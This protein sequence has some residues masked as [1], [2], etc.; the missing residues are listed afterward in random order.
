VRGVQPLRA[1]QQDH[2]VLAEPPLAEVDGLLTR[3]RRRFEHTPGSILGR[4]WQELRRHARQTAV[5][6]AAAY[7]RGA[8]EPIPSFPA[9]SLL[10]AGHQP[11]LFHPG[12]WV[13]NF[14]LHGL[15]RRH[16]VTPVNLV[17]DNDAARAT[18]LHVPA[19]SPPL[20]AAAQRIHPGVR[21]AL[22]PFDHGTAEEPYEER[23]VRDEAAFAAFPRRVAEMC[24]GWTFRPLLADFWAECGRQA[25]RTPLLGERFAAARRAFERRWG[26][27]NLEVPVS[28]LCRTEPFAWFAC[29]LLAGLPAFHAVYNACVQE[30]RDRHGLRNR[31]HP[32]PDL[33]AEGDWRELPFWAWRAGQKRR[34]RLFAR[35]TEGSAELRAGGESWPT[36]P[37]PRAGDAAP[38]V[39]AWLDLERQGL[40][41]RSRALSNT[42]YARLFLSDLFI[43]GIGGGKYDEVTDAI[44]GRFYGAEAPEYLVLS[45]TLRLPLPVFPARPEDCPQLARKLRDL[46]CNPQRHLA[47]VPANAQPLAVELAARKNEWIGRAA[48]DR[49]ERRQRCR[50]L[51]SL[52]EQF[53]PF[54]AGCAQELR[55]KL[56]RCREQVQANAVLQRRDY[57]FCLFPEEL[58]R[59]F[60]TQFL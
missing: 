54:L 28:L 11:E 34:G 27:H 45:A 35:L 8:G 1:P 59:P 25:E 6:A 49:Q 48:R 38:M 10:L 17:V 7:L 56:A 9:T 29:H 16:G 57:A 21:L 58:L 39:A 47:C 53:Q 50:T 13:K 15:A 44:V 31:Q 14:A 60:C 43:H 18:G 20:D 5:A 2:A 3:N 4:P 22:V 23:V 32:V 46:S 19:A 42:L 41:V 51:R 24:P 26:C 12:V 30:Y 52:T 36:L 55:S 33:A 40:K 37:L